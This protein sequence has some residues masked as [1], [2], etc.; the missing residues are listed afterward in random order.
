MKVSISWSG[1][2]SRRVAEALREW[3]PNV[4][5]AVDPWMSAE[6]IDKGAR[7]SSDI[8]SELENTRA[9]ILC[10]TADN[11][12]APWLNFEAGAL[13]KTLERTFVSPFLLN[14]RP[15][16]LKGPLVQF[17]ATEFN[18]PDTRRLLA[19]LNKALGQSAL[20]EK[21][22]DKTFEIWWPELESSLQKLQAVKAPQRPQRSE[23]EILEEILAL[24]RDQAKR[25][26][27]ES[28]IGP[29]SREDQP[30]MIW[31][32]PGSGKSAF[33]SYFLN[34]PGERTSS[35][36]P[37]TVDTPKEEKTSGAATQKPKQKKKPKR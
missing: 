25:P 17:Q 34:R 14:V 23:R 8:A 3:L 4:L 24:V 1:D 13:S 5:Q 36:A 11:I 2:L 33:L 7:W 29:A 27:I 37:K 19:T 31:G 30:L 22:L 20:P 16:D 28:A 21:Q 32:A 35:E 15:S 18:K 12:E 6:D 26:S 9:G 10:V